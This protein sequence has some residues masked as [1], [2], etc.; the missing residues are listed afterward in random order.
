MTEVATLP[1]RVPPAGPGPVLC[2]TRQVPIVPGEPLAYETGLECGE[3]AAVLFRV[4]CANGHANDRPVCKFH[5]EIVG[6]RRPGDLHL[7]RVC[8]E[9]GDTNVPITWTEIPL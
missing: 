9:N 5:R 6:M 8:A 2:T 7:C 1:A 4:E 3:L